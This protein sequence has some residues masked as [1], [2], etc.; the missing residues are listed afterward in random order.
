MIDKIKK[1]LP[2]KLEARDLVVNH[3]KTEQ[4]EVNRTDDTWKT[5]KLLGSLLDTDYD[6]DRRKS[7]AVAA[8]NNLKSIFQGK[9]SL[10]IKLRSFE[11]YVSSIFLYNSELWTLTESLSHSIDSFQRRLLR[12]ACLN[13]KWPNKMPNEE[14][15]RVAKVK[16][17][18]K[19]IKERQLRWFGHMVRLPNDTPAKMAF[20]YALKEEPKPRGRPKLTWIKM[21]TKVFSNNNLTWDEAIEKAKNRTDW[22]N[23]IRTIM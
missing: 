6:I 15:Y 16:P 2:Q 17:W 12:T 11:C 21:I 3:T 9:N 5:C 22:D 13:I 10:E 23:L 4:H 7:L 20:S 1:E 8:V 14:V 18:S 19:A